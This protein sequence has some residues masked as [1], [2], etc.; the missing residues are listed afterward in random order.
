[1]PT[2]HIEHRVTDYD[3]WKRLF[4]GDPAD[5][6]GAGVLRY[7]VSRGLTDP[8]LVLID[9]D[10]DDATSAERLLSTLRE[11]WAGPAGSMLTGPSGVVVEAVEEVEL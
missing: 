8:N 11:V 2:L 3:A 6:R 9:L 4:D 1:M 10:F 5:R 7:R